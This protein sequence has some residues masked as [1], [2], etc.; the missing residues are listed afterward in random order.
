M[1][2]FT[3]D[4][5]NVHFWMESGGNGDYYINLL[6]DSKKFTK[7]EVVIENVRI[8]ITTRIATNGGNARKHTK[9]ILAIANLYRA[10]EEAGLNKHPA[11]E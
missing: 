3:D 1:A 2:I 6:E 7:G 10:M 8:K 4:S 9:V 5:D 11:D